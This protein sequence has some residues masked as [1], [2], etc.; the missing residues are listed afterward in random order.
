MRL[1][2]HVHN[3]E[4]APEVLARLECKLDLILANQEAIMAAFDDLKAQ[5]SST[6]TVI[7]SAIVLI[8][9]IAARIAAAGTDPAALDR[10]TV[11]GYQGAG[12]GN[13]GLRG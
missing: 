9:G 11:G 12:M 7:D 4:P 8:N 3:D 10:W 1:D 13:S 6:A 5:V 2:I